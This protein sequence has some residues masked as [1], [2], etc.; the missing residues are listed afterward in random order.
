LSR[1]A[2]PERAVPDPVE[3]AVRYL[4]HRP[5]TVAEV[6]KHLR[7][8][9]CGLTAIASAIARVTELGYLDDR[10]YAERFIA[11]AGGR[12]PRG[13]RRLQQDLLH[14][15]VPRP[16]V[17]LVLDETFGPE[18]EAAALEGALARAM[19]GTAW[20]LDTAAR[21]RIAARLV[22]R[23]FRPGQVMQALDA[24]GGG[25]AQEDDAIRPEAQEE[26]DS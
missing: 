11:A 17:E 19:R 23:G 25:R 5:R 15:G 14:R 24:A 16:I 4:A 12:R 2:S 10:S 8:R 1:G 3:T 20:P 6:R 7:S 21:R 13:R 26:S 9:G 22:R 18:V